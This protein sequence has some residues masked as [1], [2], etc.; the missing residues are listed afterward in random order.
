[1]LPVGVDVDRLAV[2]SAADDLDL[3][4]RAAGV[5]VRR[6]RED[7]RLLRHGEGRR[8]RRV[9]VRRDDESKVR[10]VERVGDGLHRRR[11]RR[12]EVRVRFAGNDARGVIHIVHVEIDRRVRGEL[13]TDAV[14]KA[15]VALL[16]HRAAEEHMTGHRPHRHDVEGVVG[17]SDIAHDVWLRRAVGAPHLRIHRVEQEMMAERPH[18]RSGCG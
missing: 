12:I 16:D 10:E 18:R 11:R 14:G 9:L 15:I 5:H 3:E 17:E 2:A 4:A 1:M 8:R 13:E 7:G 6:Q